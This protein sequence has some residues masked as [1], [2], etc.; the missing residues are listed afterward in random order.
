MSTGSESAPVFLIVGLTTLYNVGIGISHSFT[1]ELVQTLACAEYYYSPSSDGTTFPTLPTTDDPFL[2]CS[3]APVDKRT[4]QV[5]T[6]IDT[7]SSL[8]A[9]VASLVLAKYVFPRAGRRTI[10]I[11]LPLLGIISAMLVALIPT[12]YSFDAAIPSTSTVHPTTCLN[13]LALYVVA[14]LLGVPQTASLLLSQVMVLD[15]C[16]EDEKTSAFAQV[17]ATMTL[18]MACSSIILRLV[19][20]FFG[21]D[22][23][24]LRHSGPFSPFWM[25]VI[26]HLITFILT[27]SL[28]TRDKAKG[29]FT[30]ALS[31]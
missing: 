24:V 29:I 23:S 5:E 8:T 21:L 14:G 30:A 16:R 9:C 28:P 1:I 22:F 13:L 19:L 20:P 4:S 15:V 3:V 7:F 6:S 18:G 25:V 10:G 26:S 11:A 12:H 2:W 27:K 17:Y 31:H